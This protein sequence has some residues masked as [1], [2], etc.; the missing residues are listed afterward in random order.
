MLNT[1]K[2]ASIKLSLVAAMAIAPM[3]LQAASA[4]CFIDGS[5]E[6]ISAL[7][8]SPNV[9][10]Q[11]NRVD[12]GIAMVRTN[13]IVLHD[14]PISGDSTWVDEL[15]KPMTTVMYNKIR[16]SPAVR[17]DPY[18]STVAITNAI[19]RR[20][21]L[22]LSPLNARLYMI[23][24]TIYKNDTNVPKK[25]KGKYSIPDIYAIPSF[26]DMDSFTHFPAKNNGKKVELIEVNAAKFEL[27]KN[28][29]VATISLAP[30]KYQ[31]KLNNAKDNY[32]NDR[33]A[34]AEAK[35]VIKSDEA[36]LDDDKN[37][38]SPQRSKYEE[39]VKIKK[40]ELDKLENKFDQAD[41]IYTKLMKEAA[42]AI[43]SNIQGDFMTTKV[44]LAKK[45]GKLLDVVDNNAI[46]A[47]SMF[48]AASTH[49]LK[50]GIGTL[51]DELTALQEAQGLSTL[52]GNQKEF[53]TLRLERMGK[54]ALM[55]LPNIA[56]GS[57]YALKQSSEAGRYQII[58][59]KVLEIAKVQDEV[60]KTKEVEAK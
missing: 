11:I 23:L 3:S 26:S 13:T 12:V 49:L 38:N 39:K 40:A 59:D 58:V 42:L 15:T 16:N 28:A 32:N 56:V 34:V 44:P 31:E 21:A 10:Q 25:E 8:E 53:L 27:Y 29:E 1:F 22:G 37:S 46:G 52:V 7:I 36:W 17:N 41:E 35:G 19:L 18:F 43:E 33:D 60:K 4:S 30:K 48:T 14:M 55:L 2:K 9:E 5:S 51:K 20:P 45:L 47:V 6:S 54:G 24:E 50:N 57:Y